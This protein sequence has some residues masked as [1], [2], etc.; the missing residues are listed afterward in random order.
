[1]KETEEESATQRLFDAAVAIL[2]MQ[3]GWRLDLALYIGR[4]YS[5]TAS[6]M[7]EIKEIM[8]VGRWF[9]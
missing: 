5:G 1:M 2:E 4:P 6:E 3:M 8:L 9:V 7:G